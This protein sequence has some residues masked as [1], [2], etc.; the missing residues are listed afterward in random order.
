[1]CSLDT[2]ASDQGAR[3]RRGGLGV[4]VILGGLWCGLALLGK[5]VAAQE[6]GAGGQ[7]GTEAGQPEQPPA[8]A[9]PIM[10]PD[11]NSIQL[12]PMDGPPADLKVAETP[13]TETPTGP[14]TGAPGI[15]CAETLKDFGVQWAGPALQH[16]FIIRNDGDQALEL[17]SVKASCGCTATK[18][19]DKQIPPGGEGKVPVVLNT[20]KIRNKFTKYVTVTSNDPVTPTL[21]LRISG[22]IKARVSVA[23]RAAAF[24]HIGESAE[25]PPSTIKLTNNTDEP[26]TLALESTASGPFSAELI[27]TQPGKE[28]ELKVTARPPY[29]PKLN[30]GQFVV[31]TNFES[32]PTVQVPVTAYVPPRLDLSPAALV[33]PGEIGREQSRLFRFTNNGPTPV[34]VLSADAGDSPLTVELVER[35]AGKNYDIKVGIP[36]GFEAPARG[37]ELSITLKTDDAQTPELK[38]PVSGRPSPQRPTKQLVGK[39]APAAEFTTG[40]G[41]SIHT[42]TESGR[43]TVLDFF[44]SWCGYCKKQVPILAAL[45]QEKFAD[46]PNVQFVGVNMDVMKADGV[47]D[48]RARTPEEVAEMW[49]KTGAQFDY[50]LDPDKLGRR[51]FLVSS[52]PTLVLL[53]QKGTVQAVHFGS[54]GDLAQTLER[55]IHQ[56]L[57]GGSVAD[58][59]PSTEGPTEPVTAATEAAPDAKPARQGPAATRLR[60]DKGARADLVK[61]LPAESAPADTAPAPPPAEKQDQATD[62]ADEFGS[63]DSDT[64]GAQ[65]SAE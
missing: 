15:R 58:A 52:F 61:S 12:H 46:H 39:P 26:L 65:P 42:G 44:A 1:M 41:E 17:L 14:V 48:Q 54:K 7:K 55:Q 32:E 29:A 21:R 37:Q 63:D 56:L 23:P 13:P 40:G 20:E 57:E 60:R 45:H 6:P 11:S 10:L 43:V 51:K 38:I 28:F 53:D 3:R 22:E 19:Y 9:N 47:T 4:A 50:A 33:L 18:D 36:E 35:E 49:S 62:D 31:K 8:V 25:P 5:S 59:A 16:A 24:S 2:S 30:K 34:K 64:H 27:E